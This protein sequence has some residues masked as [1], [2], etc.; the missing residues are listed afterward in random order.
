MRSRIRAGSTLAATLLV[1]A[2]CASPRVAFEPPPEVAPQP[3]PITAGQAVAEAQAAAQQ[4][5]EQQ[6]MPLQASTT[7]PRG[8]RTRF[9]PTGRSTSDILKTNAAAPMPLD[10]EQ[11]LD[12]AHDRIYAWE[13]NV[14]EGTDHLFAA[15]DRPLAPVPAAP[16]R[17]ASTLDV[18][19][20]PDGVRASMDLDFDIALHL[21]NIEKRLGVFITSEELDEGTRDP[22][23]DSQ[24]RAGLR[25]ELLR[26]LD[27]DLGVR[28]DVPPVAFT[29]VKWAREY[30]LGSIEF[31]PLL[32]LFAET[33]EGLGAATGATFDHWAGQQLLRSSSYAKW[34]RD[35]AQTEWSQTF[36]YAQA[37]ELIVPDRYG[38]FP[39]ADD[40]GRG[41]GLR[42]QTNGDDTSRVTRYESGVFFRG[43]TSARW[44]F[45]SVE[46]MMRWDRDRNWHADPGIR[47]GIDALFWDLARPAG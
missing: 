46:P 15:R 42:L 17:L 16:F 4:T 20:H 19:H 13:Q 11:R 40:I 22:N 38:S 32:K 45:W 35:T 12:Y 37:R 6:A 21:P 7:D 28:V 10:F 43:Q 34:R 31:Y 30:D 8:A 39:S 27:F 14:V 23:R 18:F 44:L 2:G 24:L 1:A 25:Y 9:G 41:W 33:K 26:A 29:S 36:I 5:V 47:F 3:P